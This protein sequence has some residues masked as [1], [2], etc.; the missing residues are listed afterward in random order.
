MNARSSAR[1]PV[2]QRHLRQTIRDPS[3]VEAIL[4]LTRARVVHVSR[5]PCGERT[6]L[7]GHLAVARVWRADSP[8]KG[9]PPAEVE[10]IYPQ[11]DFARPRPFGGMRTI[12]D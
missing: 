6:R 8:S 10:G 5:C 9:A 12:I 2:V 11:N 4:E 7:S 1:E 3:A